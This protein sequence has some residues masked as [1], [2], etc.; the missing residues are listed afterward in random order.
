MQL[1]SRFVSFL[2]DKYSSL[3]TEGVSDLISE[4][5]L[6]SFHVQLTPQ[7]LAQIEDEIKA[8]WKLRNELSL[9]LSPAFDAKGL[10]RSNTQS[11]CTSYDF[12]INSD[13]K[14]ELIE[15][16]TNAAFLA[17]GLAMY[18]FHGVNPPVN[19]N[20][21]ALIEMFANE[22]RLVG[23]QDQSIAII[24]ENPQAQRLYIEFLVYR[25]LFKRHGITCDIF[26]V[27]DVERYQNFGLI[28]NRYTDFYLSDPKSQKLRELYNRRKNLSPGPYDYF[29][30]ADKQRLLDWNE[31]VEVQRPQSLLHIYDLG[32]ADKETI[33][34]ER[35]NLFIKPKNSFGSKQAY[36][37][38]SMSRKLFDEIYGSQFVAQQL[39]VPSEIE[40]DLA[41]GRERFKYDLRCFAYGEKLQLIVA[42]LYQGQTTNLRT[43]GG[44]FA[45][46]K[47][48]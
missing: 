9:P 23:A 18:D 14:P 5:L 41:S 26:D 21:A 31:N 48:S 45:V 2:K 27:A 7:Q 4:Q 19:F 25:D 42:R 12:H 20:E 38:A 33:W 1:K 11:V 36:K 17:L 37:G 39:S 28:Y 34:K 43:P 24:D 10:V 44:G 35:K 29:L 15:I 6:S 46:V 32:K 3:S 40:V 8:Y 13:G 30:L 16:N 47:I 22:L